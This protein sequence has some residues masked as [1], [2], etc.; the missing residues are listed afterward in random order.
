MNGA[1]AGFL[2]IIRRSAGAGLRKK[3]DRRDKKVPERNFIWNAVRKHTAF[4][5]GNFH[6][7]DKN[8]DSYLTLWRRIAKV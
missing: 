6:R 7:N 8:S 4:C 1:A 2:R 3:A 5:A